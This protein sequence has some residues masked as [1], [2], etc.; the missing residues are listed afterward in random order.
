MRETEEHSGA[1]RDTAKHGSGLIQPVKIQ[2]SWRV[3][4]WSCH[5]HHDQRHGDGRAPTEVTGSVF[6]AGTAAAASAAVA[7]AFAA[8]TF[9]AA[10]AALAA[11]AAL[12]KAGEEGVSEGLLQT[13]AL[14]WV[15]LHH[16][17][18]QVKQLLVV[19]ALGHHVMLMGKEGHLKISLFKMC[20]Y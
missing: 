15:I 8:V 13:E 11:S 18:Y 2:L 5:Q 4:K 14:S 20:H 3:R 1:G 19:F 10:A 6:S 9:A 16:L 7:F 12:V 17:L